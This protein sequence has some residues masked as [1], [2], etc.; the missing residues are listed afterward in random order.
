[1]AEQ[2]TQEAQTMTRKPSA[3][4]AVKMQKLRRAVERLRNLRGSPTSP[5]RR[6]SWFQR[7]KVRLGLSSEATESEEGA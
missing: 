1:M 5:P 3:D 2:K 7:L 6:S 4:T